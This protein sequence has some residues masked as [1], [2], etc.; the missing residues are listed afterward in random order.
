MRRFKRNEV[1]LLLG[2]GAS[3]D[4]DIPH[5]RAMVQ[6]IEELVNNCTPTGDWGRY[7][8]LFHYVR[9]AVVYAHG[10]QGTAPEHVPFN[11]ETL[12]NTLEELTKKESHPLCPFIGAWNP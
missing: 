6:K 3:V 7:R 5:A 1:L 2:A 10:I 8:D 4:A 12:V 11:I 9:S